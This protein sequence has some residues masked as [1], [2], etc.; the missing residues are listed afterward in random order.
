MTPNLE[1]TLEHGLGQS[2]RSGRPYRGIDNTASRLVATHLNRSVFV[3]CPF[4]EDYLR[5]LHALLFAIQDCGFVARIALEDDGAAEQRLAKICRLIDES[6][7]SIHDISR[8]E[9]SRERY[10]RFNMPF[11]A[12]IAYGAIQFARETD[13]DMLVLVAEAYQDKM[14]LSDL[15]GTDPKAHG[16]D[17][18]RM[19][20]AVRSFLS[21]KKANGCW[22]RGAESLKHRY[23]QFAQ[24]LPILA[25]TLDISEQEIESL[26]Y[27]NDWLQMM[28]RWV[29][30]S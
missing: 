21:S 15:A 30:A 25:Q 27:I 18:G 29:K 13:R 22:T 3:N 28:S 20:T 7:L 16:R 10:P 12:G 23:Q 1:S 8:I 6:R 19:F 11:E 5:L 26:D 14:T 9:L 4:D 17:I 2:R 24:Q